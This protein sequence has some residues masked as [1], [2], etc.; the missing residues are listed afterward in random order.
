MSYLTNK[1]IKK[2]IDKLLGNNAAYQ[3]ANVCVNN[4][5][6]KRQDINRHCR[7]NFINPIKD[8]DKDFYNQI[9]LQ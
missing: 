9:I 5:K 4:S 6:T 8:I 2:R 3:A 7:V 1:S